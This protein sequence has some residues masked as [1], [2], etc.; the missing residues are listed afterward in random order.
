MCGGF[1]GCSLTSSCVSAP[2]P[3]VLGR[4]RALLALLVGERFAGTQAELD[5]RRAE[6]LEAKGTAVLL[7][8]RWVTATPAPRPPAP[9]RILVAVSPPSLTAFVN[10]LEE[11]NVLLDTYPPEKVEAHRRIRSGRRRG[12]LSV[13]C[14]PP[15]PHSGRVW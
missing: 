1:W 3:K 4:C 13:P 9:P 12:R 6:Y 8:I 5:R 14:S 7:K 11:L 2:P 15:P 10:S